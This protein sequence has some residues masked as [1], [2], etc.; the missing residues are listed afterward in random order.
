MIVEASLTARS[1]AITLYVNELSEFRLVLSSAI[2]YLD[3]AF[4]AEIAAFAR[5]AINHCLSL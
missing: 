5:T 4:T 1:T 3:M 2:D